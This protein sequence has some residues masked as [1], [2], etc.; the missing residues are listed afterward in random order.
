LA[1]LL[2]AGYVM[3]QVGGARLEFSALRLALSTIKVTDPAMHVKRSVES[4]IAELC[5][6]QVPGAYTLLMGPRGSGKSEAAKSALSGKRGVVGVLV[7]N[8]SACIA[9][10]LLAAVG[11]EPTASSIETLSTVLRH[12]AV[13]LGELPTILIE[14]ETGTSNKIINELLHPVKELTT[15]RKLCNIVVV[16]SDLGSEWAMPSDHARQ[17]EVWMDDMTLPEANVLLDLHNCMMGQPEKRAAAL[18]R[19]GTRPVFLAGLWGQPKGK[20]Y[21]LMSVGEADKR[22]EAFMAKTEAATLKD[23]HALRSAPVESSSVDEKLKQAAV[24]LL[25]RLLASDASLPQLPVE[26]FDGT[27]LESPRGLLHFMKHYTCHVLMHHKPSNTYRIHSV[28]AE[29]GARKLWAV[30]A[31]KKWFWQN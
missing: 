4:L 18:K 19:V 6:V 11:M 27:L 8:K 15:G 29:R 28:P 14:V 3:W 17:N 12:A 22:R 30:A 7:S 9:D 2:A 16:F 31:A 25:S 10:V 5:A 20:T 24:D 21:A 23:V 1:V 26:D 13:L